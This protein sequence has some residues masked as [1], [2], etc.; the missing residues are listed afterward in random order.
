MN[1]PNRYPYTRSQWIEENDDY[2]TYADDK[3]FPIRVLKNRLTREF[4]SKEVE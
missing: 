1:R 2:Y 4:K 3:C